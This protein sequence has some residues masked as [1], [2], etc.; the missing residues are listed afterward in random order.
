MKFDLDSRFNHWL[1]LNFSLSY[2]YY[3]INQLRVKLDPQEKMVK[4]VRTVPKE[5]RESKVRVESRGLT[6]KTAQTEPLEKRE[7]K[8]HKALKD[9][10]VHKEVLE[11]PEL[12]ETQVLRENKVQEEIQAR[13]EQKEM[14]EAVVTEVR[15]DC[16]F[17][18]DR[19]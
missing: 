14:K 6:D 9:L 11:L 8:E 3:P 5:I 10:L 7:L 15:G 1:M 13:Q 17:A 16:L 12:M 18:A 2:S 4:T 19:K